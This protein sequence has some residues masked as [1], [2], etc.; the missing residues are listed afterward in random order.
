MQCCEHASGER[1]DA[2]GE[3]ERRRSDQGDVDTSRGSGRCDLRTDEAGTEH[4]Q[5]CCVAECFAD[6]DR[7]IE[8]TERVDVVESVES[9]DRAGTMPGGEYERVV[10]DWARVGEQ[11]PARDVDSRCRG[12]HSQVYV[13]CFPTLC[14]SQGGQFGLLV[15][16]EQCF[17]QRRAVVGE[18]RFV[19]DHDDGAGPPFGAGALGGA[20]P[21]QG[22]TDDDERKSVR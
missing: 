2:T 7:V 5:T 19:A 10:V 21:R 17:G 8:V 12:G 6:C 13:E 1:A 3:R 14:P 18:V 9:A 22:R 16:V 11:F 15:G 20:Y 4:G